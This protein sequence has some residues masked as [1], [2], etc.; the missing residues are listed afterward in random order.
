MNK[1]PTSNICKLNGTYGG[2]ER[3]SMLRMVE[4][5]R[6]IRGNLNLLFRKFLE[7]VIQ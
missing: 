1:T 5:C 2:G 6:L 4:T 7:Q 3:I